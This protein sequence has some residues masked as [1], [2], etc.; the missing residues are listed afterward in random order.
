MIFTLANELLFWTVTALTAVMLLGTVYN[1][2]TAPNL[3]NA[4]T[5][6][7]FP[8][9]SLLIPARNE[10]ENMRTLLPLLAEIQ[11]PN[12]EILIL[13]DASEDATALL[14]SSPAST[15]TLLRGKP[16]PNDW[17]GKNWACAQLAKQS[18]GDILIFCD[19][20]V[21]MGPRSV[22][23]T[24]GMM[25]SDDLDAL[26]CLPRQTMGTWAEKAVLPVLLFLPVMGFVPIAYVSK[27][28]MPTLSLGC[29]QWFAFRRSAYDKLGTHEAVK[30]VIVED[31]ALG[32]LVKQKGLVLGVAISPKYVST[33]M[34]RSFRT[35]WAGFSKNLAAP[36]PFR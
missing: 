6:V 28:S 30:D 5:P 19:A 13:D 18:T 24:V 4:V 22:M 2:F 34:Y 26:T 21:S 7:N 17:L 8:R 35:V 27:L 9:V 25:Q 15:A 11:Y 1:F 16:L 29:G 14:A 31:M 33:R 10:E 12:L 20:D 36:S 23:A 3:D 32:R